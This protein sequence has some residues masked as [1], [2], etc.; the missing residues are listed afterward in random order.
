M[1]Q[2]QWTA[3]GRLAFTPAAVVG[4]PLSN[5][6]DCLGLSVWVLGPLEL[7]APWGLA[8]VSPLGWA[9]LPERTPCQFDVEGTASM[10]VAAGDLLVVFP[11]R[12]HYLR[13]RA[14]SPGV[15]IQGLL[16]RSRLGSCGPLKHG[17]GGPVTRLICACFRCDGLERSPLRSALPAFV[18]VRGVDGHAAPYVAHIVDLLAAEAAARGPGNQAVVDRLMRILLIKALHDHATSLP[19]GGVSWLRALVDPEIG[20]ALGFMHARPGEHWTVA[21]LAER[22]AMSRSRFA[23][24][25]TQL[26]GRP[27]LE[28]LAHWRMQEACHLLRTTRAPLKEVAA[29]VGYESASAFSKAF[30]RFMGV[31]P[32]AYR[33]ADG[34]TEVGGATLVPPM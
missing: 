15:P 3:D 22:V 8:V 2:A 29:Q 32:G 11:E 4:D 28:Y 6:L 34:P 1:T 16:E 13:D 21:A 24:R 27:P 18:H 26:V 25:F 12:A 7:S 9:Y 33:R 23:S 17:G 5:A 30:A 19:D 14:D 31:T 10:S 20:Q